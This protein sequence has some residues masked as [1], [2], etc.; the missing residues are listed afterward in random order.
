MLNGYAPPEIYLF[1][2]RDWSVQARDLLASLLPFACVVPTDQV[3][4]RLRSLGGST[5]ATL[6]QHYWFVMKLCVSLFHAPDECC[7]MDDDVFVLD[8]VNDALDAFR[9]HDLVFGPDQDFGARYHATWG[10]VFGQLGAL[11][12][13]RC[14]AWL[15]WMRPI[16]DPRWLAAKALR[17][18]PDPRAPPLWE[19]G[20][21]A[22]AYAQKNVVELP[23]QRYL[24]AAIEGL[25]GGMLGYDYGRNP[26]GFAS[27][28]FGGLAEKPSDDVALHLAPA[29]LSR[30]QGGA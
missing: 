21:I 1:G 8:R 30:R 6:A 12:T 27:I 16:A 19:Q 20:F 4:M 9:T 5:L 26:C 14:S 7:V 3:L 15:Y 28:H 10:R 22:L 11:R 2:E 17:V 18:R 13:A 25:P 29:I 24:F 23:S